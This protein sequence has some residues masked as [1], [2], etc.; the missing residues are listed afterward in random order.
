[1]KIVKRDLPEG[2]RK[3]F[4]IKIGK[5]VKVLNSKYYGKKARDVKAAKKAKEASEVLNQ[6]TKN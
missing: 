3:I 2:I 1:M 5:K 4:E 6:E